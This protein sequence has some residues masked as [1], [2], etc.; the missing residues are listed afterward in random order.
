LSSRTRWR[1][2]RGSADIEPRV[3]A[4]HSLGQNFLVDPDLRDRVVDAAGLEPQDEVLEVGAGP[5]T[6]TVQLAARCRRLVAV[7][8]D[9]RLVRLLRRA[10]AGLPNVEVLQHDVLT[11]DLSAL[12][13][14]GG[15]VVVGNIPYYL[16]GGLLPKLLEPEPRPKRL[17]LVVQKEVAERWVSESG[18]SLSTVSVRV[19]AEPRLVL[20]LP[21][22]AFSPRPKVD[23]AL[24]RLEVRPQPAVRVA[25]LGAFFRFVEQ[26]FQFRRK[27]LRSSLAR[28]TGLGAPEVVERLDALGVD[29]ARRPETL[30]LDDWQRLFEAFT[31]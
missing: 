3:R 18:W 31:A 11:L 22:E 4:R 8:V 5:G 19:F 29:P 25:D 12:F 14:K 30:N 6:L 27:Q 9:A 1:S 10:T 15:E 26:L 2:S 21:A 23:S 17:S 28:V 24:V 7:E 13:P 20:S 16:T